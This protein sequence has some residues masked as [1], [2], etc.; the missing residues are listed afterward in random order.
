MGQRCARK[1]Q[2]VTG[3]VSSPR[4]TNGATAAVGSPGVLDPSTRHRSTRFVEANGIRYA[5]IKELTGQAVE[6]PHVSMLLC[7]GST[8]DRQ[9]IRNRI[10]L[11]P[12][13]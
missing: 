4:L 2:S 13:S 10:S 11:L 6:K 9:W 8:G 12:L 3:G 7:R 5:I 1:D